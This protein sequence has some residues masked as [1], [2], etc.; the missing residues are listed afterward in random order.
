MV[1]D[2]LSYF[3]LARGWKKPQ[4]LN[5]FKSE[6]LHQLDVKT[7]LKRMISLENCIGYLF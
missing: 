4:L 5:K 6:I 2:I 7:L 3:N 1:Y